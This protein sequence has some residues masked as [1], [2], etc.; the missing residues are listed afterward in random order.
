[1]TLRS[2]VSHRMQYCVSKDHRLS[3]SEF[4][5]VA[6]LPPKTLSHRSDF[7]SSTQINLDKHTEM[8]LAEIEIQIELP[9]S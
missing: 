8:T 9:G 7:M 4:N 1:M 6:T 5:R 3:W 2:P